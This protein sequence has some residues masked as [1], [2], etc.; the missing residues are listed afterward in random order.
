MT[1]A[2]QPANLSSP[3]QGGWYSSR[4]MDLAENLTRLRKAKGLSQSALAEKAGVG[5]Q[6]ISQIEQGKNNSTK[7]LPEI[8]KAL[9]CEIGDL[10]PRFRF[11]SISD[12]HLAKK[13][14]QLLDGSNEDELRLLDDYLDFRLSKREKSRE[15]R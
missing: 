2:G 4:T 13:L 3:Q 8:A 1:V 7:K 12:S 11:K 14:N 5:Q 15:D 6:L 10:D 9:G